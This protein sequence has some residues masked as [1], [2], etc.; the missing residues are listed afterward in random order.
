MGPGLKSPQGGIIRITLR[1]RHL[2]VVLA[3]AVALVTLT[4][5]A[6][7]PAKPAD[8]N[9]GVPACDTRLKAP[10]VAPDGPEWIQALST[11]VCDHPP[12][13]HHVHLSIE[14]EVPG[15]GIWSQ[16]ESTDTN[17]YTECAAVPAPGHDAVCVRV[18]GCFD[19]HYRTTATVLYSATDGNLHTFS[20]PEKPDRVIH[21][22]A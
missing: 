10:E 13:T 9:G 14:E 5:A 17:L 1:A 19:G 7:Q 3:G 6:C 21:C 18:V 16:V 20:V 4:A 15:T 11:S 22:R 2:T 8:S 12:A